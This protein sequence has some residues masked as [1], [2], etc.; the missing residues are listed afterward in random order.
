M[1]LFSLDVA[2]NIDKVVSLIQ[3]DVD[4]KSA[5]ISQG[6]LQVLGVCLH[7]QEIVR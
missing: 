4:T 6:A 7:D 3:R 5:D 2:K 1:S